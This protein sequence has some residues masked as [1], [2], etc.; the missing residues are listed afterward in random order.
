MRASA[1]AFSLFA[2]LAAP[3]L[4]A[5][6]Q[7]VFSDADEAIRTAFWGSVYAGGGKTLYCGKTFAD[8]ENGALTATHIY[9]VK[10]IK[11]A[12]RCLTDSQCAVKT[13]QYS[14]MVA[15]LHN[16][17]P[18]IASME[19]SR[20]NAIFGELDDQGRK[21]N[22]LGCDTRATYHLIEPRDDV[23]GNVARAFFYMHQEYRLPIASELEMLKRWN[24]MDPPDEEEKA[25]NARISLLQG[26]R[27]RFIDDP[28]LANQLTGE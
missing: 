23:K 4:Q 20:R 16:I 24:A 2:A 25:R 7:N 21:P 5:G 9:N 26:T 22:D 28:S 11:S 1:I 10:Q 6:G 14:F 19:A 18:V 12:L 8:D 3:S 15:D 13:P 17:Y 27:N